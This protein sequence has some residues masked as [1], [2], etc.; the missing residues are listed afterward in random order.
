MML[1]VGFVAGLVGG[2]VAALFVLFEAA[3]EE[4]RR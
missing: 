4:T 2:L 1:M 3:S